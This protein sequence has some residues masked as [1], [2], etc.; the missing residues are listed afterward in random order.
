M[1]AIAVDFHR[2]TVQLPGRNVKLEEI[3]TTE[4]FEELLKL[5]AGNLFDRKVI[6]NS[7]HYRSKT[8]GVELEY[9]QG[10][11]NSAFLYL[12]EKNMNAYTGKLPHG[13]LATSTM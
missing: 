10:K 12:N 13:L 7:T 4:K 8:L 2:Y 11:L 5:L 1:E 9:D 6:G 3:T